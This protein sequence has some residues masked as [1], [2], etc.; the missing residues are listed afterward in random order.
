MKQYFSKLILALVLIITGTLILL[1]PATFIKI[2]LITFLS[3][4]LFETLAFAFN[5]LKNKTYFKTNLTKTL[6]NIFA[7]S[8]LL[9]ILIKAD[10]R[11]I[12]SMLVYLAAGLI[13]INSAIELYLTRKIN[14]EANFSMFYTNS[15]I[16]L[17][18]SIIM[19][20]IPALVTD[21]IISLLAIALLF[22]GVLLLALIIY[23]I[24][25]NKT[26]I[27]SE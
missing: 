17:I 21:L 25:N 2:L 19:F 5:V 7:A 16:T 26:I 4:E 1:F 24:K 3:Y 10:A 9:Y 15:L 12:S 14:K 13:F 22:I 27:I 20:I 6:I 11:N 23:K 8:A 18:I